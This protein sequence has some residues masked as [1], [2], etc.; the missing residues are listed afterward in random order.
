MSDLLRTWE[1]NLSLE[2]VMEFCIISPC[3]GK[4]KVFS[5]NSNQTNLVDVQSLHK[6]GK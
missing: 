1:S 4:G 2:S 3:L 5:D 6:N